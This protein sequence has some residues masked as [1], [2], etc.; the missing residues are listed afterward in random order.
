MAL[1]PVIRNE[2]VMRSLF[3]DKYVR[4]IDFALIMT[5]HAISYNLGITY[6]I[7]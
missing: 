1:L 2:A 7:H 5:P 3:N 6:V 4:Y